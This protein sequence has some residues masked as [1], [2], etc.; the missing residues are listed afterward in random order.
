MTSF[1]QLAVQHQ[2]QG[3]GTVPMFPSVQP[4]QSSVQQAQSTVFQTQPPP[5]V[6]DGGAVDSTGGSDVTF[7]PAGAGGSSSGPN[8][9]GTPPPPFPSFAGSRHQQT[10]GQAFTIQVKPKDPPVFRGRVEDDV[11]T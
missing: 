7:R 6:N 3:Y 5:E 11:T 4:A 2:A 9:G 8:G 1:E 10:P